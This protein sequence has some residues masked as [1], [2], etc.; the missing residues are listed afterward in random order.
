M[1]PGNRSRCSIRSEGN[2]YHSFMRLWR[3]SRTTIDM[4][5]DE[6]MYAGMISATR[7][8]YSFT[9]SRNLY[10]CTLPVAVRGSSS[11][12]RTQRGYL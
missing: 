3:G 12:K 5:R 6:W 4:N 9:S 11:V 2:T 7:G 10:R 1:P 8:N